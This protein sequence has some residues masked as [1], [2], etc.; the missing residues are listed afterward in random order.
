MVS[1]IGVSMRL[2]IKNNI[3]DVT[4]DLTKMQKKQIPFA[5]SIAINNTLFGLRKEMSKQLD[6]K[7]DRPTPFTKRGFLV[8]KSKKTKLVGTLF[9]K[10]VVAD[11][12]Q[13]QID[14][15]VRINS[16]MIP[17]PNI[18]NAKLN[19]YGNIIGKKTGLIKKKTQFFGTVNSTQGIWERTNKDQRVKLI[20]G[21][22]RDVSYE[23]KFPFYVIAD[24][25]S[26]NTFN[27]NLIKSLNKA[28]KTAK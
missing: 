6:K 21:L 25:Y 26:K 7:L 22:H 9:L 18:K 2:N 27:K 10:D 17:V 12:L 23:P 16:K 19:K 28:L 24:K 5:T 1:P 14:G 20:I 15:G 13:Y 11:Y 3:K 8:D 4:K